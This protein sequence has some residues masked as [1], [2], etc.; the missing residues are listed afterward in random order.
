MSKKSKLILLAILS[1]VIVVAF[2]CLVA[3]GDGEQENV[4]IVKFNGNG[5]SDS[6]AMVKSSVGV[7]EL[8]QNP[9]KAGYAFGGWYFDQGV[10]NKPF[11]ADTKIEQDTEVYAKWTAEQYTLTFDLGGGSYAQGVSNPTSYTV[12]SQDIVLN[13]AIREGFAFD[14]W[15]VDG[16]G[17]STIKKGSVGDM[18]LSAKWVKD[19]YTITYLGASGVENNNP[20]TY[21]VSDS[22]IALSNLTKDGYNFDG[23]YIGETKYTEIPANCTGNLTF[24]AKWTV[25]NYT[26]TY[27][28][29]EGKVLDVQGFDLPTSYTIETETIT[30]NTYYTAG[31]RFDGWRDAD[32]S[33]VTTIKKGSF[34]NLVLTA[35][36]AEDTIFSITFTDE[37]F[38]KINTENPTTYTVGEQSPELKPLTKL[39][40][41]FVGWSYGF[42]DTITQIDTSYGG[43]VYLYAVW[44]QKDEFKPF[45]YIVS[46]N[47]DWCML[48]GVK[49]TSVTTLV[50]PSVFDMVAPGALKHCSSLEDLTLAYLSA[51]KD[52]ESN[53][54]LG[55]FFGADES[56]KSNDFLPTSLKKVSVKSGTLG[57]R[58]FVNCIN[59]EEFDISADV[60]AIGEDAFYGCEKLKTL[61]MPV[62]LDGFRSTDYYDTAYYY[63][64]HGCNGL[65]RYGDITLNIVGGQ[66]GAKAFYNSKSI[67][68]V[69]LNNVSEVGDYAF[70][71]CVALKSVSL[72][73]VSTIGK[74]TFSQCNSLENIVAESLQQ[75][76]K[77]AFKGCAALKEAVLTD[78]VSQIGE[79]TFMDCSE[80]I[81]VTLPKTIQTIGNDAFANCPRLVEVY[82]LSGLQIKVGSSENGSI[83]LYAI[84]V[85]TSLAEKSKLSNVDGMLYRKGD[86]N[87]VVRYY[88][89]ENSVVVAEGTHVINRNAFEGRAIE[90]VTLPKSL[91][92]I[93]DYA[94]NNTALI[95]VVIPQR[96]TK[97]GA[98]AFANN[99]SLTSAD[100]SNCQIAE[101]CDHV[102]YNVAIT[103]I[104]IPSTVT[105]IG[106]GAFEG[107]DVLSGH[108][109]LGENITKIGGNVFKGCASLKKLTIP[110]VGSELNDTNKFAFLFGADAPAVE[111]LIVLADAPI[112]KGAFEGIESLRNVSIDGVKVI[113]EGAFKNCR[114]LNTVNYS[115]NIQEISQGAF[116]N[117]NI[118]F[119]RL[120]YIGS[121][122]DDQDG[123]LG[124]FFGG[125][126]N[127][128]PRSLVHVTI[129]NGTLIP[130][131]AF[132]GCGGISKIDLPSEV[133]KIGARAFAGTA[134]VEMA[135]S[136]DVV[137]IGYG[138]FAGC[139]SITSITLP[140][141]GDGTTGEEA[142]THFGYVFGAETANDHHRTDGTRAVPASL[143]NV[144]ILGG[145]IATY[146]FLKCDRVE[147]ITF[148]KDVSQIAPEA[149]WLSG[150]INDSKYDIIGVYWDRYEQVLQSFSVSADSTYFKSVEGVLYSKDG[151]QLIAYPS[152]NSAETFSV[153]NDVEEI[154]AYAFYAQKCLKT[155]NI[156]DGVQ[157]F[158]FKAFAGCGAMSTFNFGTKGAL[159]EIGQSAFGK[160]YSLSGEIVIPEGVTTVGRYAFSGPYVDRIV[161]PSTLE[162]IGAY[163]FS[164]AAARVKFNTTCDWDL[165]NGGY[166]YGNTEVTADSLEN[167]EQAAQL[168]CEETLRFRDWF[169]RTTTA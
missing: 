75:I 160:C 135:L 87:Y 116:E 21:T 106:E 26:I 90:S 42:G 45:E 25:I 8:P 81:S 149:F 152:G 113:G 141:V 4:Y 100:I 103:S 24:S 125:E 124:H 68:N 64:I 40:Y 19:G 128:I 119:L 127:T 20:R 162:F 79:E 165:R 138:A 56:I 44:K 80:L 95:A 133:T 30:L 47:D 35:D 98:Y 72:N 23:W 74:Y 38:G 146:A 145:T 123:K 50:V 112:G 83:G 147:T 18:S 101:L 142:K 169:K 65:T 71:R 96:V 39:D 153:P 105:T 167:E 5:A 97:I 13:P 67:T 143:K 168:L 43:D 41:D 6:V 48:T 159:K 136:Q 161:L 163:G 91:E 9:Q 58:A 57:Y 104:T 31:Y 27:V 10:W 61:S 66:I 109:V 78:C 82:N 115:E 166:G 76:G 60:S 158:G 70:S 155:I 69:T 108:V 102:F 148:G 117:T 129:N 99:R 107:C 150:D 12:E 32:G 62:Y 92:E 144:T 52:E 59:I 2:S 73:N 37:Q 89:T 164:G 154:A 22:A 122:A 85:Y 55:Y 131:G 16:N 140:F 118:G 110:F 54:Y 130:A 14:G 49:D 33:L 17:I 51:K 126:N 46:E 34:G 77:G 84:D 93:G 121:A 114:N 111:E 36:L 7:V 88:G 157:K 11:T 94:F 53:S 139:E 132:D 134:L 29:A 151:K 63:G 28:D 156:G 137:E 86:K 15:Y 3:C 120:P 1:V